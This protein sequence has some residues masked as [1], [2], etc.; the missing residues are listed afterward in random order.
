MT[1]KWYSVD[2]HG[3]A[4]L[5]ADQDDAKAVAEG[6]NLSFPQ[7]A[8]HH[9]VQLVDAAKLTLARGLLRDLLDNMPGIPD[10]DCSCHLSP[11]CYD[12]TEYGGIREI[13]A[14]AEAYLEKDGRDE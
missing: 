13:I 14:D 8:P 9:A 2:Q 6:S 10:P 3:I 1:G 4:T 5:C 7:N 12:C 11:P